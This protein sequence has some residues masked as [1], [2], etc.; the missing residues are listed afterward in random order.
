MPV[1]NQ[2]SLD[3][4]WENG[5]NVLMESLHGVGKTAAVADL[6][7]RHGIRVKYFSCATLDPYTDLVGIPVPNADQTNLKMVRPHEVDNCEMIFFDELNRAESKV[8]N[9]VLEIINQRTINGE[10]LPDLRCCWAAINPT[11]GYDVAELDPALRD[12]FDIYQ[13]LTPNPDVKYMVSEG[14]PEPIAQ[15][16]V[17]WYNGHDRDKPLDEMGPSYISPRRLSKMAAVWTATKNRQLLRSTVPADTDIDMK[18]L[19]AKLDAIEKG[20]SAT[21]DANGIDGEA[22]DEL[23]YET[24]WMRSNKAF[25]VEHLTDNPDGFATHEKVAATLS[26]E[27]DSNGIGAEVL[28]TEWT[29]VLAALSPQALKP[30]YD[31]WNPSK[32]S[33]FRKALDRHIQQ[34]HDCVIPNELH[35]VMKIAWPTGF[36]ANLSVL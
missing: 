6:A 5:L 25:L 30:A 20:D 29:E 11:E 4:C 10:P 16:C 22:S 3:L 18:K 8:M 17:D 9:A 36:P 31:G 23:V 14:I 2:K 32:R 7:K 27:G 33:N 12:R 15:A 21:G 24:A 26:G 35:A 34:E 13:A 19:V 28:V 1:I